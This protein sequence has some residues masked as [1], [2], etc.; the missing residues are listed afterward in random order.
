MK[1][2][3]DLKNVAEH[4]VDLGYSCLPVDDEKMPVTAWKKLCDHL[5]GAELL[6]QYEKENTS[7]IALICGKISGNLECLDIDVKY[8]LSGN[9]FENYINDIKNHSP[10]LFEKLVIASTRGGGNHL[11]YKCEVIEGNQKLAS[12]STTEDERKRNPKE[13]RKVLLETRGEGGYFLAHPSPGYHFIK[14][15]IYSIAEI[16]AEERAILFDIAKMYDEMP[17]NRISV[18]IN[19]GQFNGTTSAYED[20]NDRGDIRNTLEAAG[21]T[22]VRDNATK[23]SMLRPGDTKAV[24]SGYIFKDTNTFFCHSTST[25]F[26]S[27]EQLNPVAV[28]AYLHHNGDFKAAVKDLASQG[29]GTVSTVSNRFQDRKR[30]KNEKIGEIEPETQILEEKTQSVSAFPIS[31]LPKRFAEIIKELA[32][33]TGHPE[34][35]YAASFLAVASVALGNTVKVK[36]RNGWERNGL[37]FVSLVGEPGSGKTPAIEFALKPVRKRDDHLEVEY[38]SKL[39]RYEQSMEELPKGQKPIDNP[40][41]QPQVITNDFTVESL[42]D[43]LKRHPRGIL[44]HKDELI[45]WIN[46]FNQYRKGADEQFWLSTWSGQGI[47]VNRK[48]NSEPI[49]I[50]EPYLPVLGGIQPSVLE[51]LSSD[52][53]EDN[54]FIDRIL[55]AFPDQQAASLWVDD[56]LD[57]NIYTEYGEYISKLFQIENKFVINLGNKAFCKNYF[58]DLVTR[59]NNSN[60]TQTKGLLHKAFDHFARIALLVEMLRYSSGEIELPKEGDSISLQSCESAKKVM[61]YFIQTSIKVRRYSMPLAPDIVYEVAE[62]RKQGYSCGKISASKGISKGTVTKWAKKYPEIFRF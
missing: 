12:R 6:S 48:N 22:V 45:S 16:T 19:K 62:L 1:T 8:D 9:L 3:V 17:A 24:H 43:V 23:T 31:A 28:Y 41:E 57:I 50:A 39:A 25:E 11:L 15:D 42:Y 21:W 46:T 33:K 56:E 13:K 20:F 38:N 47:T 7:G 26:P 55:F 59:A 18:D 36:I 60:D 2:K 29:Y 52:K 53:R 49:K 54:G 10:A 4:Y 37:L 32:T 51:D 40:P 30:Q 44:I 14:G 34:D 5:P 27:E 58:D 35:F 61:E